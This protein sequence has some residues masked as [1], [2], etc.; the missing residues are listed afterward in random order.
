MIIALLAMAAQSYI[1]NDDYPP[2][3]VKHHHEGMVEIEL[4]VD[5]A[6]RLADCKVTRSTRWPE[7]DATTCDLF[8]QRAKY[9]PARDNHGRVVGFVYRERFKWVLGQRHAALMPAAPL[10][11]LHVAAVLTAPEPS[12]VTMSVM[13]SKNGAILSCDVRELASHDVA[14]KSVDVV[15]QTCS[16]FARIGNHDVLKDADGNPMDYAR[17]QKFQLVG[18]LKK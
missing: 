6:G 2:E 17:E 12:I 3:A 18:T 16:D 7:L 13:V 1:A 14:L 10:D 8:R 4:V 15:D 5:P 11:Q 9:A